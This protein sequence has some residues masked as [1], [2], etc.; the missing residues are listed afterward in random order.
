MAIKKYKAKPDVIRVIQFNG[1]NVDE[2]SE[3]VE[4][5]FITY[6]SNRKNSSDLYLYE[7]TSNAFYSY[8]SISK[9]DYIINEYNNYTDITE[10]SLNS[11][12]EVVEE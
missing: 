12:Y 9:G 4:G 8:G 5:K 6:K 10:K 7:I 1:E 3:F 2:K 11:C